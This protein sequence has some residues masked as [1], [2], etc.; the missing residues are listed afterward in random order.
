MRSGDLK[1][2]SSG[3]FPRW[4]ARHVSLTQENVL[5][6]KHD[7]KATRCR[8]F[9]VVNVG[10]EDADTDFSIS[11]HDGNVLYLRASS[12]TEREDWVISLTNHSIP[13]GPTSHENNS[14]PIPYLSL[15]S[16]SHG[17]VFPMSSRYIP[18]LKCLLSWTQAEPQNSKDRR[19]ISR[20][21]D[22]QTFQNRLPLSLQT[23]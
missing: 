9:T 17:E 23:A 8:I 15:Q 21:L 19:R 18:D 22:S 5:T 16:A 20:N 4:Q 11:C 12:L 1:K 7:S 13:D 2:K 3:C 6:I 14:Q 10:R